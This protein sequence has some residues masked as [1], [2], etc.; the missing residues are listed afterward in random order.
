[1]E[2]NS[3][4]L[5]QAVSGAELKISETSSKWGRTENIWNKQ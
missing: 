1:V 5:K 2:Q 3:K 4:Y